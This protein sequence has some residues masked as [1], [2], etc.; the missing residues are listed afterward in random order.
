MLTECADTWL[1][2]GKARTEK[3]AARRDE[4]WEAIRPIAMAQ[5]ESFD[6]HRR[7]KLIQQR[8]TET[9]ITRQKIY[10]LLRRWWQRGM[11]PAALTPD[12]AN[13]GARVAAQI[14]SRRE[15]RR[16]G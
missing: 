7:A 14:G 11:T 1:D 2:S 15:A 9:G 5:P 4:A 16:P 10:R 13:S 6:P 3:Q 12:Y 8:V